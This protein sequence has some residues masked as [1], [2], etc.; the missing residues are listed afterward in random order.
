MYLSTVQEAKMTTG[1]KESS[2]PAIRRMPSYLRI[3][4][5][6][7]AAD[8]KTVSATIL[9]KGLGLDPIVTRKDFDPLEIT[10]KSGVGYDVHELI[11]AIEN[12]LGWNNVSDAFLVGVGNLGTALLGY[13]GFDQYGLKIVLAFDVVPA[14]THQVIQEVH[15]LPIEDLPKMAKRMKIQIAILAVPP[16]YAQTVATTMVEAGIRAIWNFAPVKLSV[17]EDVVVQNEDLAE[18]LAVLSVKLS[19]EKNKV[20]QDAEGPLPRTAPNFPFSTHDI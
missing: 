20:H 17:P 18:G 8:Q 11:I 14:K 1:K 9:A 15:V 2:Y 16:E 12:E 3:L 19:R 13:R 4:K 7:A 5:E 6:L 10:G